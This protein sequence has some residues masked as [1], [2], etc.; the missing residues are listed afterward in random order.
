VALRGVAKGINQASDTK[1]REGRI[2]GPVD[3]LLMLYSFY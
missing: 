1:I 3:N 2:G